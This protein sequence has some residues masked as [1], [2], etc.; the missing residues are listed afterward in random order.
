LATV[1]GFGV[2][3]RFEKCFEKAQLQRLRKDSPDIDVLKGHGFIR[4]AKAL[5]EGTA[6]AAEG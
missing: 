3:G 6:L 2:V 4:A 5:V 1:L